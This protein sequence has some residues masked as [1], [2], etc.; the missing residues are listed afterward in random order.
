MSVITVNRTPELI[1]RVEAGT[2]VA[3][4]RAANNVFLRSKSTVPVDTG[5]LKASAQVKPAS[6]GGMSYTAEVSFNTN[7]ALYVEFGT[8]KMAAQPYLVPAAHAAL[9]QFKN[10]L[11]ILVST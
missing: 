4:Q 5:T 11:K 10:D 2:R 1:A 7:Y 9:P 3:V 6:G 8:S